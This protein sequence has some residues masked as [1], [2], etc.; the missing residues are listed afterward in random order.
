MDQVEKL[1]S[2][3]ASVFLLPTFS[4]AEGYHLTSEHFDQ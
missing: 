3:S 2:P 1:F 4:A